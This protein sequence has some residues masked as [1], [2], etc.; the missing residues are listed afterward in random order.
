MKGS[1]LFENTKVNSGSEPFT[2]QVVIHVSTKVVSIF[3]LTI[4][5]LEKLISC[6]SYR[7]VHS[8]DPSEHALTIRIKICHLIETVMSKSRDL[9]FRAEVQFRNQVAQYLIQWIRGEVY[10]S[11]N[12]S[13][14]ENLHK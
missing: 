4:P 1:E 10:I 14:E 8:L 2:M 3:S 5:S 9:S 6:L 12:I 7:Y 11:E 13:H